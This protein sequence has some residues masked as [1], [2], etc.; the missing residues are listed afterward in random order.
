MILHLWKS[1]PP[2]LIMQPDTHTE[3]FDLQQFEIFQRQWQGR[4]LKR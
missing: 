4:A 3:L 1:K 2:I